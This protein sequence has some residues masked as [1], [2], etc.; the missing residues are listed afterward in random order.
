MKKDA[1]KG[2]IVPVLIVVV[3]LAALTGVLHRAYH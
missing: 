3:F 2:V 1:V